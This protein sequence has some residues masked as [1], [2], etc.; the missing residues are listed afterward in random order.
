MRFVPK[1]LFVGSHFAYN[2]FDI[3]T[4][5]RGKSITLISHYIKLYL[6]HRKRRILTRTQSLLYL[7][8]FTDINAA[9]LSNFKVVK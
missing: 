7:L 8:N 1:G 9:F 6:I 2:A 3:H 5:F 4:N